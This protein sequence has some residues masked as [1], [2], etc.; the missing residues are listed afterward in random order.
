VRAG[1]G[2][3][4]VGSSTGLQMELIPQAWLATWIMVFLRA[5]GMLAVFPIFSSPVVPRRL[6][7]V[8][9]AAMAFLL[10]PALPITVELPETL[11]GM[12]GVM[13]MEVGVGLLLGFVC[14]LVFFAVEVAGGL[15]GME[16][17]LTL[18][19]GMDPN[20]GSQSSA[21]GAVLYFLAIVLWLGLDLHHWVLAAFHRTYDLLPV[22]GAHLA[23][24]ALHLVLGRCSGLFVVAVQI[25]APILAVSFIISLV[26]SVLGR[27]VP[28][29]NVFS[30]S[31]ALRILA[32]LSVF[33]LT[34]QVMAQHVVNYLHRLPSD[35]LT[36]ARLLAVQP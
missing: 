20:T 2:E 22:G 6:R 36:V 33:G 19:S 28:Q 35:M 4:G 12:V 25:T 21:P 14:R 15:I 8:L 16:I 27:A 11:S 13:G 34:C 18:P 3:R 30:E 32:G 7:V 23:E 1:E 24:G 17:G 29:M 5:S 31:F 9:G 10:A 26:F